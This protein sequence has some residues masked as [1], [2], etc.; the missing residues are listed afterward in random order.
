MET[1]T[2]DRPSWELYTQG[3]RLVFLFILFLVSLSNYVDRQVMSV[4]LEPIK[5]EFGASDAQMGLL[6]GFAFAA[7]YAV[8]GLPVAW[9]ADR[10]NRRT[11]I[12][13]S[14]AAWSVMT[15]L[16]GFAK[17]FPQLFLA[18]MG[19]GVGEAGAI[20][21]AQS[22]IADYFPPEQR[23]RALAAFMLSA[24]GGYLIAFLGGAHLAASYGWRTAF[25]ALGAPGLLLCLLTLFGLKEPRLLPGRAA[26]PAASERLGEALSVLRRK[27]SFVLICVVQVLYFLVA[28]GAVTWFPAYLVRVLKMP[29]VEVGAAFGMIGAVGSLV[30]TVAGGMLTDR[31]AKRDIRWLVW[32][33]GGLLIACWPFYTLAISSDS[34]TM[35]LAASFVAGLGIAAAVPAMFTVLHRVCG[36]KRRAMAV[37]IVFFFA[38]LLGLGFGPLITGMLSDM[39]TA[40]MGPVG[41]RYAL[42]IAISILV[43]TGLT[44][45]AI[46][47][48]LERDC[49]D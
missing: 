1:S 23:A 32:L 49:E 46:G 15:M 24:T 14:L 9:L 4:L 12:T 10:G 43:P 2:A 37:A 42:M 3:Q 31:L 39:F 19:V 26:N 11:V 33:P 6:G 13:V 16:C 41:L 35:F 5:I 17:T 28:Y 47:K 45:I 48:S 30:G 8:L 25:I 34:F 38:N 36:S 21:P 20:P 27:R 40:S 18:R 29:L 22:L 44:L 7:F